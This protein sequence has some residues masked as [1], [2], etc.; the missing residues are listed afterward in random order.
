[1]QVDDTNSIR[2]FESIPNSFCIDVLYTR[3]LV[4]YSCPVF[5]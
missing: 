2:M 4:F 5:S 1:M 3:N